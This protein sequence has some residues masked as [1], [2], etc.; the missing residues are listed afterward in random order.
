VLPFDDS[1]RLTGSNLFFASTG[2]VLEVVA[3]AVDEQLLT[4][5][6]SR[7]MRANARLGWHLP[8]IVARVHASG[9]SLAIAAPCDLL[10]LATEVNE[11]AW[12]S[13]VLERDPLRWR[14][15]EEALYAEAL[16]NAVGPEPVLR[17]VLEESAAMARF[18]QMAKREMCPALR[19]LLAEC[20][21][22]ELPYLLDETVLTLGAGS[23]GRNF[24]LAALPGILEVPWHELHDIPTVVVTG[25]NGKTT[26]VRLLAACARAHGWQAAYNCTDGVFID[27]ETL[28]SGD[29]SGP[30]GTRLVLREQR[31]EAAILETARGGILRRGIAVSQAHAAVITNVSSDHFGEY[32]IHD[33]EGLADVKLSVAALLRPGGLLVLNADDAQL[34]AKAPQLAQRNG[35]CPMLGWFALDADAALLRAHRAKEGRTCGVRGGRLI[36]A[37]GSIEHDLGPVEAMPLTIG[38]YARYN[39]A[40]LAGAALAASALG[41]P[42]TTIAAV[43]ARFGAQVDDNP[44]R[45]MRYD[46]GGVRILLDY[47]HN[48]DG[49]RGFLAVAEQ[50]RG[51]S[52]RFGLLLGHAGNRQ[53]ADIEELARVAAQSRPDLV[54]VKEIPTHL[55]GRAPGEIPRIIRD[56]LLSAG[57]PGSAVLMQNSE[58]EAAEQALNWARPGDVLGLLV[59]APGARA[60]VLAMLADRQLRDRERP[61]GPVGTY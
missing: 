37:Y 58:L 21:A 33:L 8:G 51:A 4:A 7:I 52:G 5:W 38:G 12:C 56:A 15:L 25:S 10:Y 49:L 27:H 1:R 35:A 24:P 59:H 3:L 36:L 57:V 54:V 48:P 60:A 6:R 44:G 53:D 39:V 32:G 14:G 28:A 29:Y 16:A 61:A 19:L 46:I 20:V 34:R 23:G 13:A 18:E 55:R 40:N 42:A 31:C 45:M 30:A 22:R 50:L 43:C 26:T 17:P 2:A 47:A 41:I 9:A 11:W